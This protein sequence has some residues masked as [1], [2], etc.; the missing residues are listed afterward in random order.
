ML[1][2]GNVKLIGEIK[3]PGDKSI[4][5]RAIILASISEGK[6]IINNMLLSEDTL[7]TIECFKAL[8]VAITVNKRQN[9]ATVQGVGL[10]G[11]KMPTK[12]LDCY[13]SGTTMRLISGLLTGQR[14]SSK[15]TGDS[16]L[17]K[18]PMNR[19]IEPLG[20]MG[21][22]I[23]GIEDNYPPLLIHPSKKLIGIDY[24]LPIASAQVKSAILLASLYSSG[25]TNVYEEN[26]S[27]DH[28]ERM[29][30]YLG[31][32]IHYNSNSTTLGDNSKLIGKDIFVPGDISSASFFIVAA[33]ILKGSSLTIKNVGLNPTRIGIIK[34]LK[35]MGASIKVLNEK[36]K[37]KELFG[38]LEVNYKPLHGIVLE[39]DIIGTLIDEI[40][41]IAVAAAFAEGETIIRNAEE[42]K[43]KETNRINAIATEL[44]KMNCEIEEL[45]DGLIIQGG[46]KLSGSVL[47][48]HND[49]RIAMAL[50]IAALN[51]STE[52]KIEN[53]SC[54][55]ISYPNFYNDL[56]KVMVNNG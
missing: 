19:I 23:T 45:D 8:G 5:H 35:F 55:D 28:T 32:N 27:R 38:D 18:R 41:I 15:V 4:S 52:S 3:V 21:A 20:L 26:I 37:N 25:T 34:V 11:L 30:E 53:H 44:R 22:N 16:S 9:K 29:L 7:R 46:Q 40:P 17:N 56:R 12:T 1:I 48:S 50:A 54:V 24:T 47:S 42:L 31:A 49:H 36:I 51:S 10:H 13:N 43:Y 14:F 33:S 39:S 2:R 6:T